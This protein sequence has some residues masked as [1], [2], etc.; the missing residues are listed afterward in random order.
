[1]K[2]P[3][4]KMAPARL[5]RVLLALVLT[6]PGSFC[7]EGTRDRPLRGRCSLFGRDFINTFDGSMYS[8]AGDCSFLL[9]GDCQTH[10][11][12]ILGIFQHGERV[13][14]SVYL[15]EFFDIHLFVNGTAV[16]G[17][18][19]ISMPYASRGLYLET[20]AGFY[21]LSSEAYGF[22]ARID[23]S[24]NFQVLLSD[25]YFNKTCGLCGDFNI[26]SEDD[27]RT[28]EGTL[29][30]DPYDFANSWALSSGKQR[31]QRA[32]PPS[33]PCNSS[34]W[35][36]QEAQREQ[37]QLLKSASVF[38]RCHPLVD[39]EPFVALCER[40]LCPCALGPACACPALLEYARACA[41]EGTVL[42]GWTDHS[43]C[44]PACPAGMEYKECVSPCARTC[45]SL[46]VNEVCQEQCVDGCSC[47]EAQLLD[48][49][50][51][52]D[53]AGCPCVHAG[54][55]YPPGA[56]LSQDC[57]TCICRNSLWIC[58]NEGCPGECLV[59]GQSHFKSFDGRHFT[60][61]GICQ[62]L[63][64]R[65]C[66]DH[67][68]S[69]VIETVQC[70]EDPDAV[71]TRSVT[72]RLG[73]PARSL[74]KLKH[75][76]GVAVE[77]QDVQLPLRQGDLRIQ[78]SVTGS[79]RLSYGEDLQM[80]WDG[81]GRLLLK[82]SPAYAGRTCGL[83][84]NYNGNKGDDF[85]TPSGL[86]ELLVA[87]F[88]NAWKLHW[89]CR[90]L[91]RQPSDPCSLNPRLAGFAE[92]ACALLT[93]SKFEACHGAVSPLPYLQN[94]RYD[95]CSCSDGQDCLCSAVAS[96][97]AACAG[98]GVHIGWREPGFCALSCPQ[99]QV[100]LQCGAPCNL[101]CRSL[102]YPEEECTK[103]CMEGCFC[104][105]GLFQDERGDC[106]PKAQCPCYHD[107]EIFQPADI[108]S[109]H[110]TTCYCED[111]FMHCTES[112]GPRTQPGWAL[113]SPLRHHHR[114]KRSLFCRP[115]MVK[116]VCP[117]DN[118]RA[119]G[120]ECA[121][122][123]QNYDLE[124]MGTGC[125][126]G[127]LCP[128]G[129]VRHENRCVALERCP[130]FH[131][132]REFAPGETVKIGCNTCVCEGRKWNCTDRVC[133]A[134]CS[135]LGMAHYLTF[136]GLKYMF[137]GECQY[138]L[139]QDHCSGNPGTFRI[140]VGN[141][142]CGYP[143]AECRK[144]VT[145]LAEGGEVELFD[146]EV[147]V[148][149]PMKDETHFEVVESGR[150]VILLL[151]R[152]LSVVWD[153]R[154][155]VSVV[156]KRTLQEQVCG[157]CGNFDGIQ[158]NDLTSS[159][160]RVEEN[161]V[162]FGNSWKVS[163]QCA[164]TSRVVL[165]V[166]PATCHD[167][168]MKQ[169][170]VDSSCRVLTSDI[171]QDCNKLVDPEPYLDVCIYDTCSC[172]SIGDCTCFCDTIAAY[173]HACAQQGQV[174]SWRT[175]A[176]CPQSCEERHL[177]DSGY[178]CEW[179]YSSCV[180]ACP[181]TCQHPEPLACP[182]RCVEGCQVQ[183]PPGKI[184]DELLQ[185]C[186]HPHDCPVCEV[187]GRRLAPGRK[188]TLNP[189]DPA[190][191]QAC[192]CD[193]ANLT[194]EACQEPGGL[195]VPP[196]E[197]SVSTTTPYVEDTPEPPLHDFYCSKLLDLVFLLDGSSRLSE[198]E[199]E[200]LKAFVVS[201]MERLHISQKRIR[202][203]VV[204]YHDGSHAYLELR[205]R[206][207]P[208]E[209]RRIASQ[210]KY[211]G[212]QVASTSEVLKYT[213]FQ[214]FGKIDRPE[215]SRIVLL[216]TAS[217]EPRQM[218]RNLVRYV[219]GLKKKKVI[220]IPVGIGPH[221]SLQQIRLIEKQAPEN[222]AFVLSSVDELEQWRDEIINYLCDHAP[223]APGPTQRTQVAQVTVGPGLLE[224]LSPGPKRKPMVLDVVFVLEGSDK[225]GEA[226][227]NQS[228]E[229]MAEVIQRMDVGQDSI[230]ITVLQYSYTVTV[231]YTF[232]KAQSKGNVLQHV[233][234]IQF[235]GGNKTNTGLALQYVSEHSFSASQ[236]DR[237][238]APNLVYMVTG[239]PASDEIKRLPGDIQ[240]VPIGVGPGANVQ[241]LQEISWPSTPIFIQDFE[242]LPREAPDL[243]LQRCCSGDT[244]PLPTLHP[245]LDCSQ[246]LDVVLLLDGSS[247]IPA[248]YFEEM[249]S[250][251][252]AFISK[253]SIGPHL[254]QVSVLQYGSITT[255][256]VPW[257]V[258][259]Q[260][261]H[262][263][264]L[265]ELMRQEGGPSRMG[266]ALAFAVRYVTSQV[267]GARPVASKAV[268]ILVMDVS[269]DSVDV[270]AQAAR[271]NRVTVF[272]IGIG[273]QYDQRQLRILAGP[274]ASSSVVQL[275][276]VEDLPTM[277]SVGN[278]F[279]HKLCSGFARVCVDED[280]NEKRP[281]DAW[282]LP[283]QCHTV[284]CLPDG[285]TMLQSHRVNCE[286][287][288]RPLCPNSQAPIRVEETCGCRW[289][290]PCVCT[291][292][293]TRHIVTFDGQNFRL[294]GS[295]S[296]AL[297]QNKEQDLEVI[298]HNGACSPGSTPV[299]MKS[300]EVK[301]GGLSV[302]LHSDMEVAVNGRLVPVPYMGGNMEVS[303][304][305]AIMYEVRFN[306][307]G[308]IFTF[309]P[310]NNEF[311]L[312]LSP[313]TF[314][315]KMYG[316]C[317]ICDENGAN[318]F[319]L[320]NGSVT[321]DWK[322]LIQEWTMQRP[323][324]P[325]QPVPEDL[326]PVSGNSH[327][328]VLLSAV[329][330][331]CHKVLSPA[332]FYAICQQ[333]GCQQERVC[334]VI[335]S[336][337]H[338][339]R[340]NG[341]CVDW[342]TAEFCAMSCPLSLVYNHC[343]RGCPRQ[344][345]GNTTSCGERPSEGCFC[346]PH[347]ALLEGSCV[348]EEACTECVGEDKARH[349]LL[350]S[351]VPEHQ[352]CQICT[353]LS[354][355]KINCTSQPC[356]TARAP[357]CG[358]CEVARLRQSGSQCCLEYECVCDLVSCHLPPVPPCE[359]GLQPTLTNPGECRP[360]FT[361]ACRKEECRSP[362]PPVCPPHRTPALRQTQCCEEY[363]CACSCANTTVSCPPGYLA[364]TLTNDCGCSTTTCLPDKVCVH[365]STVYP[366]G[367]FWEEGCDVCTCTDMEDAVMGLRVAQCS[368]KPCED[369]CRLGFTYVLHEGECCG[370]CLPSAC[371][372]QL[373]SPRGDVG[374][375]GSLWKSVGSRWASPEDPCLINECV[376]VKDEVFVQQ[377]NVSCPQLDVPT[378]PVGFQLSCR[379]SECCPSCHCEPVEAC[380][381]NGTVIGPGKSVLVDEC[382]T[383]HCTVQGGA[384]S[385]FKLE[386][387]KTTCQACPQGYREEKSQ[388]ECCGRCL[389]TTCT[390][391]L[392]G[393]RVVTL[394]RDEML[395]D[396]C[397]SHFC[398]VNELG[399]YIWEKRVTGCPPFDQHRCLAEGGKIMKIPGTCCDT[400]EGP[401]CKDITAR[402]QH[403]KVGDCRSQEEVDI[404]YCE[405]K[406]ASK[407][408]Y[409]IDI[410][411]VEDQC[412]CCSPARTEP[413]W[414]SLLCTN[415]SVVRHQVLNAMQCRCSPRKCGP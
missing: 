203:A 86:A 281:G 36:M 382:T 78:H 334:E 67:T 354:G 116:F 183:C 415:G 142:G 360:I 293:S 338:L 159:S 117:A 405:G 289:T 205:A 158:N 378:C 63:L 261:E 253:A 95:V 272:P 271:S 410:E 62:Y 50:H 343:E 340:T 365:H 290:C 257:N 146:G 414:V 344:C 214:I 367:Q 89:D 48:E 232:R 275:P 225:I 259:Q 254:M 129:M 76:G 6:L 270:A 187:A 328:Q 80:D 108:F 403:V 285:Q 189:E 21:K 14:L 161:A 164:D 61:S 87:D 357:T 234:E 229:F 409:S 302:E 326:C 140:L 306:H 34:S 206:K 104:P 81:R 246:P 266:E 107:G 291:G 41:Q 28:Q 296:Y 297:F 202:V 373:G 69:V 245:A 339:C 366:V 57:N 44:R 308:H 91:Q 100:Y 73:A 336:Y 250:F 330:S 288:P 127:C 102:S 193:G 153:R 242:T 310:Q 346:P 155:G 316:L 267:H 79:V 120:M 362:P 349:Q 342:R 265:V 165:D 46:H 4:A 402:L 52:V 294:T 179:R 138:I 177:R 35:E 217:S 198:A 315:S 7:S 332:T 321:T 162:D 341:V 276:R 145:I 150:F 180:P 156:L 393:G 30:S 251:A 282:T 196:T 204:E 303:V 17:D 37:C 268:L 325:C 134:T 43:A 243:V 186:V 406:C 128:P 218:A 361:C 114:G 32:S 109:D 236:G 45:Q 64:A 66:Q 160:L 125:V 258:A 97:A 136:D 274:D 287:V 38:A 262:L 235:R 111:G 130:C 396:G 301:H 139:V 320:R 255:I 223:E 399:E 278:S 213:L 75:G 207:R 284:T 47:P 351:W 389:P 208:S 277:V 401:D 10:S 9:A 118:P 269:V 182:V 123:C 388:G 190:R 131:Q 280:G 173:A 200:T 15:G 184:L 83:C 163:P 12:S 19:G 317:G 126:S 151:G 88:G 215:A 238:Q 168:V 231:E 335:A 132:G 188:I 124:C 220:V 394:K 372:L 240:V 377:R 264:D 23:N 94:C 171:F 375:V 226:N 387:R 195:V 154:L 20:E 263:L 327:C 133:D 98:R 54:K 249:K 181:V 400:C 141:E 408:V 379:T 27:F 167:N 331:E 3:S 199:F 96:Y 286:Q 318:D 221:A 26:F 53:S 85:L 192:H 279:F 241:E 407:A 112:G 40:S 358:P 8:F 299:C 135:T 353:C 380:L 228:K 148:K 411:A 84:G 210:V 147:N 106:V 273:D 230:H 333:D 178:E 219:Q 13:G 58:S 311:Q 345:D 170:M 211:A 312:Q 304:Y 169:T 113:S 65:D 70:A 59:T 227:F 172:E 391:Q 1:M 101:T 233:Q 256:D 191:C 295:C 2:P 68:F 381:V 370:R 395:Q 55:R 212:S 364:S 22:V 119:E 29:T 42:D 352:P 348:P 103:V 305:G 137:P 152:A 18:Q 16:Q 383:C 404:H 369:S 110:H 144:R 157:L 24:G 247:G 307:L 31:C 149:K 398:K 121:K 323:G 82:L 314:A 329:F 397:D 248:S 222:K 197:A 412:S 33:S 72:A 209:L 371:E 25:R 313:K 376:Q 175:A 359:G 194:C 77:G 319:M 99:G 252:K 356:P 390:I 309:T 216:L 350:E 337:T 143:S 224:V 385:G 244:V 283:D 347:H 115:P 363:E 56:S 374:D 386:C 185:T 174:V 5:A 392:R 201:T 298:L 71:C 324:Q 51:C 322:T 74:V 60:F 355:R 39:P 49:G 166:S 122:T 237:E 300:I 368:Q 93:S 176:L 90:D 92:E 384:V 105:P 292:S 239:N 260:K 413:M 11:F